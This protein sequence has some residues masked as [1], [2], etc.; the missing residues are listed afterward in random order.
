MIKQTGFYAQPVV[1]KP[2]TEYER[3]PLILITV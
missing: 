3:I 1:A 2:V